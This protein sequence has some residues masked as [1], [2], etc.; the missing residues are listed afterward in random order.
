MAGRGLTSFFRVQVGRARSAAG[1]RQI[2]NPGHWARRR[3]GSRQH[4]CS[5][6]PAA[7]K[8]AGGPERAAD[9]VEVRGAPEW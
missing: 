3:A 8:R 7:R 4:A 9:Q 5:G 1:N 2:L 6:R